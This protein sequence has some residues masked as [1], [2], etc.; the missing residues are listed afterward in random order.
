MPLV[1]YQC[2]GR[3]GFANRDVCLPAASRP[4]RSETSQGERN[5]GPYEHDASG[6]GDAGDGLADDAEELARVREAQEGSDLPSRRLRLVRLPTHDVAGGPVEC[7]R[8]THLRLAAGEKAS[9]VLLLSTY[10]RGQTQLVLDLTRS[11]AA[12]P[13]AQADWATVVTRLAD[14]ARY[15]EVAKVVEAGIFEDGEDDFGEEEFDFGLQRVLDGIEVL[16]RSRVSA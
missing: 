16:H 12:T 3:V 11:A 9:S 10:V 2:S 1:A 5:A 13:P 8:A 14:P 4:P 6:R 15:P 7:Q